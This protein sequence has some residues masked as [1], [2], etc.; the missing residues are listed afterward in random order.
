MSLATQLTFEKQTS[1]DKS[2]EIIHLIKKSLFRKAIVLLEESLKQKG[3]NSW[4]FECMKYLHF[5]LNREKEVADKNTGVERGTYLK[6]QWEIFETFVSLNQIAIVDAYFILKEVVH[7]QIHQEFVKGI[8]HSSYTDINALLNLASV[9]RKNGESNQAIETLEFVLQLNKTQPKA[10]LLL[11]D[12]YDQKQDLQKTF[13]YYSEVFFHQPNKLSFFEEN[14]Y[15]FTIPSLLF[16]LK[17]LGF[18]ESEITLWLPVYFHLHYYSL[19]HTSLTNNALESALQITKEREHN[20]QIKKSEKNIHT[21]LLIHTYLY[22]IKYYRVSEGEKS[23]TALS[24]LNKVA[25]LEPII[26]QK[27]LSFK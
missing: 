20:Y 2:Q 14:L 9:M 21:P 4:V 23:P 17:Q 8:Q 26:Y 6:K 13:F 5:W 24:F 10:A 18:T 22:L 16:K 11:A 7:K 25:H 19:N 27:I 1:L 12:T 3:G 15:G